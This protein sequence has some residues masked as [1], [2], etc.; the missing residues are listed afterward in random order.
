MGFQGDSQRSAKPL[1]RQGEKEK[2]EEEKKNGKVESK[3]KIG[4]VEGARE[5][6]AKF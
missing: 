5:E 2:E 4:G 1:H 3:S 6:A